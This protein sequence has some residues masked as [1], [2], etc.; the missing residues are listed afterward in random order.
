MGY[1][2]VDCSFSYYFDTLRHSFD[3]HADAV[4]CVAI[5]HQL[6]IFKVSFQ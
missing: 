3:R 1:E 5:N 4:I 6:M 2:G